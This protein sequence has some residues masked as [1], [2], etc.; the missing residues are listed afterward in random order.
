LNEKIYY[1]YVHVIPYTTEVVYVGHGCRE[2]AWTCRV[3]PKAGRGIGG[4]HR[5]PDHGAWCEQ[6]MAA[7]YAPNEW[8]YIKYKQLD[9]EKAREIERSLIEHYKPVFNK[10]C[11]TG[12]LKVTAG[13][14]KTAQKMRESGMF[15][16]LIAEEL[17]VSTMAIHRALSGK[18]KN[19]S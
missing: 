2:R 13:M 4:G 3:N 9:K 17:G 14:L 12:N 16:H 7:G 11:G 6:M 8:V 18:T 1:V 19:L 10:S 15:Y 5:Q